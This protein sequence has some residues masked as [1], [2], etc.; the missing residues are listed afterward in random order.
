MKR[1]TEP[2]NFSGWKP[3]VLMAATKSVQ[4]IS[5]G[6]EDVVGW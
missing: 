6:C 4:G 2:Y 5:P 3:M 1:H